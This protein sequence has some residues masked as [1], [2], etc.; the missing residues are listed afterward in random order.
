MSIYGHR[1]RTLDTVPHLNLFST[2]EYTFICNEANCGKQFLTSYSLRIHVRV[3]TKEKPFECEIG[4]CEKTFNTVYRYVCIIIYLAPWNRWF[5]EH[6]SVTVLCNALFKNIMLIWQNL[7]TTVCN[8]SVCWRVWPSC[9][10]V[11]IQR[12]FIQLSIF[13]HIAP[14]QLMYLVLRSRLDL[15]VKVLYKFI[16]QTPFTFKLIFYL[17][18]CVHCL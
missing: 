9:D 6:I 7:V 12:S 17:C 8:P 10:F 18:N 11:I 14:L 16:S 2:G 1:F 15:K 3:H 5:I 4:G 13:P